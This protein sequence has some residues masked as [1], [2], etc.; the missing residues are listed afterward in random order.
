MCLAFVARVVKIGE[1]RA[2]VEVESGK[3]KE[4]QVAVEELKE[5]DEVIVQQGLV[6]EKVGE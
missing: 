5:G 6:V 1:K 2:T 4:A 3:R